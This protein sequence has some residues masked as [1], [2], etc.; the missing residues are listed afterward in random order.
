MSYLR[1]FLVK[2]FT[3]PFEPADWH[4]RWTTAQLWRWYEEEMLRAA[5]CERKTS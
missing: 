4:E 2:C 3:M 1:A 5:K